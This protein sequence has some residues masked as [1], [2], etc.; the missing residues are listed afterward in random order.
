MRR[1]AHVRQ[2]T[3]HKRKKQC[4]LAAKK[5]RAIITQFTPPF[6]NSRPCRLQTYSNG[7]AGWS[8]TKEPDNN[9]IFSVF[10]L[11]F[12][13][14]SVKIKQKVNADLLARPDEEGNLLVNEILDFAKNTK[15]V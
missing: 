2:H 9:N 11:L 15:P 1:K 7:I 5:K 6:P 8:E 12:L 4:Y 14:G 13:R 3:E 10:I